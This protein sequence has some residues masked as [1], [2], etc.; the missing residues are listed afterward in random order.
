MKEAE[1]DTYLTSDEGQDFVSKLASVE[2]RDL[3]DEVDAQPEKRL[4]PWIV[5][6]RAGLSILN[7]ANRIV[8]ANK[9][10]VNVSINT[11]DWA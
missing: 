9:E 1:I 7:I 5:G 6:A 4:G 3:T 10:A 2:K 11:F 8:K